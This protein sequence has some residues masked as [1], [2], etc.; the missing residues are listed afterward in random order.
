M[1]VDRILAKDRFR[2]QTF[3]RLRRRQVS[4]E[5]LEEIER[6]RGGG[7]IDQMAIAL[8]IIK[9]D[10]RPMLAIRD[11]RFTAASLELWRALLE[12]N[13]TYLDRAACAVGRLDVQGRANFAGTAWLVKWKD[14]RGVVVTNRHVVTANFGSGQRH[15]TRFRLASNGRNVKVWLELKGEGSN[16]GSLSVPVKEI[17]YIEPDEPNGPTGPDLAVLRLDDSFPLPAAISPGEDAGED[18]EVAVIGFPT[19]DP[20]DDADDR[21][22]PEDGI[23]YKTLSPGFVLTNGTDTLTH[24]ASTTPGFSGA[25]VLDLQGRAVGVNFFGNQRVENTAVSIVAVKRTLE[26]AFAV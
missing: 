14:E 22:I 23:G 11:G 2:E 20:G 25:P 7:V 10:G 1:S 18:Q 8:R 17:V 6:L 21:L 24:D 19:D 5:V 9:K 13:R 16:G 4:D 12:D 15:A 26:A 3:E